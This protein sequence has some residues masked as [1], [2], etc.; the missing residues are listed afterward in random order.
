MHSLLH[1]ARYRTPCTL[2]LSK[3]ILG[4]NVHHRRNVMRSLLHSTEG[5][6]LNGT[7]GSQSPATAL[8]L[9]SLSSSIGD[10]PRTVPR[11][12]I[13][14]RELLAWS[15][16]HRSLNSRCSRELILPARE[17]SRQTPSGRLHS[18]RATRSPRRETTRRHRG[19]KRC[20]Q[21]RAISQPREAARDRK[22]RQET[23]LS[24]VACSFSIAI[25]SWSDVATK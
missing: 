20:H 16:H 4:N 22:R 12:L 17:V 18:P 19:C 8:P 9:E 14:H 5:A 24:I 11:T 6:S 10:M 23:C 15:S 21:R 2:R 25:C 3:R 1:D 7:H 13:L